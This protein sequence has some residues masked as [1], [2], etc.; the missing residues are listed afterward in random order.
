[1]SCPHPQEWCQGPG[2]TQEPQFWAS[3]FSA[4][5]SSWASPC[6]TLPWSPLPTRLARLPA[7]VGRPGPKA[8]SGGAAGCVWGAVWGAVLEGQ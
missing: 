4:P 5:A 3:L 7:P 2:K 1:M 6:Q 8:R